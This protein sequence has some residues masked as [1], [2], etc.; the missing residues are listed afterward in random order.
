MKTESRPKAM[1]RSG[2]AGVVVLAYNNNR[3]IWYATI[4]LT[5][6]QVRHYP[7]LHRLHLHGFCSPIL[8]RET[9]FFS[10]QL[11]LRLFWGFRSN[12]GDIFHLVFCCVERSWKL[13]VRKNCMSS[14]MLFLFLGLPSWN[15]ECSWGSCLSHQ[16]I[17]IKNCFVKFLSRFIPIWSY[18][19]AK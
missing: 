3:L 17:R 11:Y 9:H 19:N 14:E 18:M 5:K 16:A 4:V 1:I 12:F 15:I 13:K 2:M 6:K 8:V 10:S 7:H